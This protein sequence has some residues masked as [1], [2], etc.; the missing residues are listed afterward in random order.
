MHLMSEPGYTRSH[1]GKAFLHHGVELRECRLC[2]HAGREG[3]ESDAGVHVPEGDADRPR[4]GE[5]YRLWC[6]RA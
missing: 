2:G 4:P 6:V 3:G 5:G 1:A